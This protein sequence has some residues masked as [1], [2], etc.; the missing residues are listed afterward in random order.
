M[1]IYVYAS[2]S[3]HVCLSYSMSDTLSSHAPHGDHTTGKDQP[4]RKTQDNFDNKYVI[5]L[6]ILFVKIF[7]KVI[8]FSNWQIMCSFV[9]SNKMI[10]VIM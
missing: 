5:F 4:L 3:S 8:L 7:C 2:T 6:K 10:S 9:Y 1:I